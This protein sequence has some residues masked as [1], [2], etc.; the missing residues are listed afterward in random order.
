ME[1]LTGGG[2]NGPM[3]TLESAALIAA[4]ICTGLMA[5]LFAAFAYAVMPGLRRADDRT[6]TEAMRQINAAI[7][8]AWFAIP[9][10]G[11]LVFTAL[12][13]ALQLASDG[14][15]ALGWT[16]GGLVL[17]LATLAITFRVNVPLNDALAAGGS[18]ERF[19]RPWVRANIVRAVTSTAA[20]GCLAG[21]L[22]AGS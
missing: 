17:Y 5:G 12:A 20:L 4:T 18:R 13:A 6:F 11:A 8:N 15:A 10:A 14:R 19:E 16:A 3:S 9:L 22:S 1:R 21:A 7:L 2:L